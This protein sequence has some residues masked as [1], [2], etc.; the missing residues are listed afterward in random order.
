MTD[1]ASS[2]PPPLP[3]AKPKSRRGIKIFIGIC[4]AVILAVNLIKIATTPRLEVERTGF[5]HQGNII[6]V[7]NVGDKPITIGAVSFNDRADCSPQ[8]KRGSVVLNVG[9][10]TTFSSSCQ[11]I[12][13]NIETDQGSASY[14][15]SGSPD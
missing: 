15:F 13:A 8:E 11:I 3:T 12:R 2:S 4:A 7:L 10:N 6:K 9:E 1:Q 5:F 14:S